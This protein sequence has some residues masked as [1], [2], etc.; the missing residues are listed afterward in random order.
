MNSDEIFN[1]SKDFLNDV[2]DDL[3]QLKIKNLSN[4]KNNEYKNKLKTLMG[5]N[6]TEES[7]NKLMQMKDNEFRQNILKSLSQVDQREPK[8]WEKNNQKILKKE[9]YYNR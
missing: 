1:Y 5:K 4:P 7:L 8:F 9:F 2:I 6:L 3:V